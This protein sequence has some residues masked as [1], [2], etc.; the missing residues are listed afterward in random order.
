MHDRLP[1]VWP[2]IQISHAEWQLVG[3]TVHFSGAGSE[4][5]S[6]PAPI[7]EER[8]GRDSIVSERRS[9]CARPP[10]GE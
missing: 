1:T 6:A 9:A 8:P 5:P 3:A 2:P 4:C 7:D 10:V